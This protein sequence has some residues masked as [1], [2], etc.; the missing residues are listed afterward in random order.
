[1][2]DTQLRLLADSPDLLTAVGRRR[3][4]SCDAQRPGP[5]ARNAN[6]DDRVSHGWYSFNIARIYLG[7]AA[8]GHCEADDGSIASSSTST[9]A[10][11]PARGAQIAGTRSAGA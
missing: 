7:P 1:M 11:C 2:L 9:K 5:A 6:C 10:V 3:R 8:R 4:I